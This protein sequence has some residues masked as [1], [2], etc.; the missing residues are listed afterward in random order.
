MTSEQQSKLG[1][2]GKLF[3]RAAAA[4]LRSGDAKSADSSSIRGPES[5]IFEGHRASS[6]QGKQGF[7][8]PGAN[9]NK[10][11]P[12]GRSSKRAAAWKSGGGKRD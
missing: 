11:K 3:G 2:A 9:K 7:K 5:F 10:G 4:Q 6:K 1:R 8:F 12:T